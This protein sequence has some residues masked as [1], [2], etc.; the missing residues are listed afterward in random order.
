MDEVIPM[1]VHKRC[2]GT[3]IA[4]KTWRAIVQ[5]FPV[6]HAHKE[7]DAHVLLRHREAPAFLDRAFFIPCLSDC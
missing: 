1:L 3:L 6:R 4:Q 2:D 5:L 7:R